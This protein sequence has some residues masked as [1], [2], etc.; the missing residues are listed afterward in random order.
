MITHVIV[1]VIA[2]VSVIGHNTS[3]IVESLNSAWNPIQALHPLKIIDAIWSTVMK[4]IYNRYNRPQ[5]SIELADIPLA[6]FRDRLR[7]SR[8]YTVFESGNGIYQVQV[9]DSGSKF[10]VDLSKRTCTC[11]NFY[12][13]SGPCAYA[14]TAC[15]FKAVDPYTYFHFAYLTRSYR[16]TYQIPMKPISIEDLA[17]DPDILPPKPCKLRGRPKTKR[18]RKNAWKRQE[19]RCGNYRQTGHNTRRCTGLPAAKNGRGERARDWQAID[20]DEG[21]G[22][23]VIMV[24]TGS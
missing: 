11:H 21:S 1:H 13:Y 10:T 6:K 16:K 4:T 20:E 24:D 19:R 9:P 12:E 18:I 7:F 22:S 17:L 15:R 8:R 2:G 5:Q 14:I 3:N 23:D